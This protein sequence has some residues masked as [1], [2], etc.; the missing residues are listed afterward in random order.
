[1]TLPADVAELP[2]LSAGGVT[3]RWS[4][5]FLTARLRSEWEPLERS[6]AVAEA[7]PDE[8]T[9]RRARAAFRTERRLLAADELRDWLSEHRLT[10]GDLDA[11][12]RRRLGDGGV[13][14]GDAAGSPPA[15]ATWAEGICSGAFEHF[16]QGLATR[17][18]ALAAAPETAAGPPRADWFARMPPPGGAAP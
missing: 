1:M 3:Y 6:A 17:A 8:H 14:H 16:A 5:V 12:L 7:A 13:E 15:H 11:Y 18:A 4:D 2:V 9:L 10:L